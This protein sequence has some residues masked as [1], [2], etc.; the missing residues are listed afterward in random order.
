MMLKVMVQLKRGDNS[1]ILQELL[2][3]KQF[4]SNLQQDIRNVGSETTE[5]CHEIQNRLGSDLADLRSD[6][7]TLKYRLSQLE[8]QHTDKHNTRSNEFRDTGHSHHE[9]SSLKQIPTMTESPQIQPIHVP[10]VQSSSQTSHPSYGSSLHNTRGRTLISTPD[11]FGHVGGSLPSHPHLPNSRGTTQTKP[12]L[13]DGTEDLEEYLA[14]F[15]IISDINGWNYHTRSLHLA[16]CLN[17]SARSILSELKEDE[18]RDYDTIVRSLNMRYGSMERAEIFRARLQTRTRA[19]DESIP[20]LAHAIRK[21]TRQAYPSAPSDITDILGI[22][23]FIDALPDFDMRLKLRESNPKTISDAELQAIRLETFRLAD[24]QRGRPVRNLQQNTD[25]QSKKSTESVPLEG[26]N[27]K[28]FQEEI[29]KTINN[30][31]SKMRGDLHSVTY[32]LKQVVHTLKS[33]PTHQNNYQN[34]NNQQQNWRGNSNRNRNF[35]QKKEHSNSRTQHSNFTSRN[36]RDNDHSAK[37]QNQ[38]N[39]SPSDSRARGRH[40]M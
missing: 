38:G 15:Q 34:N 16:G 30:G 6:F 11:T 33:L 10:N 1:V 25:F 19:K 12:Q 27:Q 9:L 26:E 18:R 21:L 40:Q 36:E 13:Y 8:N 28:R 29:T 23:H 3:M 7:E 31:F 22:D 4:F 24:K 5:I 35:H 32:E 20:E 37:Y 17:G 14:H 2:S 39:D